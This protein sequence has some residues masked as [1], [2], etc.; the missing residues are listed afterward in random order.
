MVQGWMQKAT[1][2]LLALLGVMAISVGGGTT[3]SKPEVVYDEKLSFGADR[4][5][6]ID[7]GQFALPLLQKECSD[8]LDSHPG[9][10]FSRLFIATTRD[11]AAMPQSAKGAFDYGYGAWIARIGEERH[12]LGS[13]AECI[14]MGDSA[15][16]RVA[17]GGGPV[18]EIVLRGTNIMHQ[19]VDG[20]DV[21]VKWLF[22]SK[23][24]LTGQTS[25]NVF[26]GASRPL[27]EKEAVAIATRFDRKLGIRPVWYTVRT[28][29]WFVNNDF[30]PWVN[31]FYPATT[32]PSREEYL[33]T[34]SYLCKPDPDSGR[35]TC[36][37]FGPRVP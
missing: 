2:S 7:R 5:V 33:K 32:N 29:P 8:F 15:V 21:D 27:S 12:K 31:P 17:S 11:L 9:L 34:Y 18:R 20:L 36:S 19:Q 3:P 22:T 24:H 14:Q 10:K 23:A 16:L 26:L 1:V 30:Y 13:V 4:C 37:K 28:D 25:L 35:I 6:L